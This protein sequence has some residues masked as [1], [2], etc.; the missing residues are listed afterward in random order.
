MDVDFAKEN[1]SD[2][3]GLSIDSADHQRGSS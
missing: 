1:G 2:I 3:G